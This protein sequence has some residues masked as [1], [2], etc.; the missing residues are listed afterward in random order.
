MKKI[1]DI[2]KNSSIVCAY[3]DAIPTPE[4]TQYVRVVED[5]ATNLGIPSKIFVKSRAE[6]DSA[7]WFSKLF[8]GISFECTTHDNPI[9]VIYEQQKLYKNVTFVGDVPKQLIEDVNLVYA[10]VPTRTLVEEHVEKR[11]PIS[12]IKSMSDMISESDAR[13]LFSLICPPKRFADIKTEISESRE[14]FY[15]NKT[16]TIGSI[17]SDEQNQ[18]FEIVDRG[19]N[20]VVVVDQNGETYKKFPD[21]LNESAGG[22]PFREG[23]YFK[24][25]VVSEAFVSNAE[26]KE[27][28]DKTISEYDQGKIDDAFAII[29]SIKIIDKFLNGDKNAVLEQAQ[30][31]LSKINQS[32]NHA[33]LTEM[34]TKNLET[35]LQAARIIAGAV[36][37]N[38]KGND[39]TEIVNTA[40][41][42][43]KRS[44]NKTQIDILKK[45]LTTASKVGLKY[46]QGL[47]ESVDDQMMRIHAD[48]KLLKEK[49]TKD[50]LSAHK[51]MRKIGVDYSAKDVGGKRAMIKDILSHN[52]G[53]NALNSYSALSAKIRKSMNEEQLD[54]LSIDTMKSY[55]SKAGSPVSH[56]KDPIQAAIKRFKSSQTA[57]DKIHSAE[58]KKIQKKL[59]EDSVEEATAY[60]RE[61]AGEY[62]FGNNGSAKAR[63]KLTDKKTKKIVSYHHSATDAVAARKKL[64]GT[65]ETHSIELTE[66]HNDPDY[67]LEKDILGY[68]GLK[69]K[70]SQM[71]GIKNYGEQEPGKDVDLVDQNGVVVKD[72]HTKPGN[73]LALGDTPRKMRVNKL[74]E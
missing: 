36:G 60:G 43:A 35:Q 42:M 44:S 49:P 45:M 27:S 29:K 18:L 48:R 19:P 16:H 40:I 14:Q 4:L 31:S 74:R 53:A 26:I 1:S 67:A 3:I 20:Y 24:G 54:E 58:L 33:Y 25:T 28:F 8:E 61:R 30:Y 17:V 41:K 34:I 50:V 52:H 10:Y 59:A 32:N 37:A 7:Y 71:T 12:F 65:H 23:S 38:T 47:L 72:A 39:P 62:E 68:D 66:V 5:T 22:V 2:S 57:T 64:K 6:Y 21:A 73:S 55:I 63:Y 9:D 70:L 69:K 46:D 11:N 13:K 51:D 15:Q 56:K